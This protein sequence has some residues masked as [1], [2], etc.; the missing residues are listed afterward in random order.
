LQKTEKIHWAIQNERCGMLTSSVV[1]L[2]DNV[3]LHKS[4]AARTPALLQHFNWQL[5]D[6]LLTALISLRATTS[7]LPTWRTDQ[8][9][10]LNSGDDYIEKQPKYIRIIC[11]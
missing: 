10:C 4:T 7:C 11:V 9:K 6:F 8:D 5:F 1:L 3:C 2:H